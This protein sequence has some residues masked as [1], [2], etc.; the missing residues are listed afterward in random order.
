MSQKQFLDHGITFVVDM[1]FDL[2]AST[3]RLSHSIAT[4]L[5]LMIVTTPR[6]TVGFRRSGEFYVSCHS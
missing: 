5:V 4:M 3:S 1:V 2:P 6:A